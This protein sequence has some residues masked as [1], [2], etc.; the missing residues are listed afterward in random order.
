MRSCNSPRPS[1]VLTTLSLID[2]AKAKLFVVSLILIP[3]IT[4][5]KITFLVS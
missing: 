4:L 1:W 2:Y 5:V 3:H